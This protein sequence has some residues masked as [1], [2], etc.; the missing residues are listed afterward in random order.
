[1]VFLTQLLCTWVLWNAWSV[2]MNSTVEASGWQLTNGQPFQWKWPA[3][4]RLWHVVFCWACVHYGE[5]PS[6]FSA[7]ETSSCQLVW[8]GSP[9]SLNLKALTDQIPEY[10]FGTSR[11]F[12]L[13]GCSRELSFLLSG[14]FGWNHKIWIVIMFEVLGKITL[15]LDWIYLIANISFVF[16]SV[17]RSMLVYFETH[18]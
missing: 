10:N 14:N 13:P 1:M 9:F 6:H 12:L 2:E 17:L 5:R 4:V 3:C 11:G 16:V 15:S 18:K 8:R 7:R